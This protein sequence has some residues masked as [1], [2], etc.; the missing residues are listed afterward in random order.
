M[1]EN[2]FTDPRDGKVYRTVKIGEQVWMAE[3]LAYDAEGSKCYKNDP[4]NEKK[5]GR[6]YNW[7]TAKKAC[8]PGW[9]LPSAEEWLEFVDF[10][11][12]DKI[13]GTKLKA[14]DA[15]GTDEYGFSAL[16]GNGSYLGGII[17][18][19]GNYGNWWSAS[20]NIADCAYTQHMNYDSE[21]AS[22]SYSSKDFLYSVRCIQDYSKHGN[23]TTV[24]AKLRARMEAI[25]RES[26]KVLGLAFKALKGW[27]PWVVPVEGTFTDQRDGKVYRTVKIGEQV[28]MAENLAYDAEGSKC[29][30]NDPTN[31]KKYGRYYDWET[32]K[33]VCPSGWHL[34]SR[35]EWQTL[36]DFIGGDDIAGEKLKAKSEWNNNFEGGS[37]CGTDEYGFSALPGDYGD[38]DDGDFYDAGDF[39]FWWSATEYA[40]KSDG[41]CAYDMHM[42][43][44]ADDVYWSWTP[45][46][47]WLNV[48]CVRD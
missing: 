44:G 43:F 33:N 24:N 21:S 27:Q 26:N 3:N 41:D 36:V 28:W 23:S 42:S 8:P 7:K 29:Y 9:H 22:W 31:E 4:T 17:D 2:T 5:Y 30:K 16:L 48:R 15:N 20:E 1:E 46:N 10:V 25:E 6:Y 13:A 34:P 19:V 14:K 45:K 39:G 47:Y 32:A 37:G 11:G 12:G 40:S 18:S 35:L 38:P